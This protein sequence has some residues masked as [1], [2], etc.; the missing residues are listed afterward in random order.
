MVMKAL[1]TDGSSAG[2]GIP[3]GGGL[4]TLLP[5]SVVMAYDMTDSVCYNA[6]GDTTIQNVITSPADS[7]LQA[8]YD[9]T[10]AVAALFCGDIGKSISYYMPVGDGYYF[11][12]NSKT[13]FTN[14][15]HKAG[16]SWGV[17]LSYREAAATK[18]NVVLWSSANGTG[19]SR[20]CANLVKVGN[21]S[22]ELRISNGSAYQVQQAFTIPTLQTYTDY[23]I[24]LTFDDTT[25]VAYLWLNGVK[26]SASGL[27]MASPSALDTA[28]PSQFF[29]GSGGDG[30]D[31]GSRYYHGALFNALLDDSDAAAIKTAFETTRSTVYV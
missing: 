20:R 23:C 18:T 21:T 24:V 3:N 1:M 16:A 8:T 6:F 5:S 25:G 12:L 28:V 26:Y 22:L 15:M 4:N 7:E 2:S 30:L 19:T 27:T 31:N 29:Y 9:G 13:T 17:A 14:S 11:D 10:V